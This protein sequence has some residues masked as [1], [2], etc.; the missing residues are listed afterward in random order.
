MKILLPLDFSQPVE[1]IVASLAAFM[2]LG[3]CDVKLLYVHELLPA[4]ENSLRSSGH[5]ADDWEQQIETS[6][7]AKL[8]EA[9]ACLEGKANSVTTEIRNGST[10]QAIESA[11]RDWNAEVTVLVPRHKHGAEK[12]LTG[13]V[14]S[15]VV[16][17]VPGTVLV[18]RDAPARL[19][20]VVCGHDGS[21][22][23]KFAL[24]RGSQMFNLGSA[25]RVVLCHSVDLAQ[26]IKLLG[27]VAFVSALEQNS[28]MQ[29]EVYLA[30]GEKALVA[31][32]VKKVELQLIEDDPA[33]GVITMAKDSSADLV[34]IG[35][36]GHSAVQHF[37]I[38]S[39]SHKIATHSPC[40]V[41]VVK[42]SP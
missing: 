16:Q 41:A 28:L 5:F 11:A 35:G 14:T 33:H 22:T 2:N 6:I 25:E 19:S 27:P 20:T 21:E 30:D 36:Q 34:V 29:G 32:G 15:K 18:L 38:G 7:R 4:Y 39:V 26:P 12:F 10:A 37:L 40:S 31:G 3:T 8:A 24:T 23:S 42:P 9:A 17:H 1:P 13:S